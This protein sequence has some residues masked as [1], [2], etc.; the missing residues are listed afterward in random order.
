MTAPPH[1]GPAPRRAALRAALRAAC[2]VALVLGAILPGSGADGAPARPPA[3][4][5]VVYRA[6]LDAPV[7]VVRAFDPPARP[8]LAGHRG[9]DLAA[10]PGAA[11]RAP[12]DGTVTFAGRVVDRGVVT[13]LHDD[14]RRSSLEPVSPSVAAG[15]HVRAGDV[16]GTVD[17]HAH[18]GAHGGPALHW[19]VREDD[20]YV[21]PWALLPG[22]GPVVLLPVP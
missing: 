11:V 22:R 1:P 20:R 17:G 12:A 10:E 9:V 3:P 5:A 19:G 14:G 13:V 6:P 2:S 8:W 7:R 4:A 18:G 16:L 15:A 21:N